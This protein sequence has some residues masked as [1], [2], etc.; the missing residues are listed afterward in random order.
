MELSVALGAWTRDTKRREILWVW[1]S[2]ATEVPQ[3]QFGVV[4][5]LMRH[6]EAERP[7]RKGNVRCISAACANMGGFATVVMDCS[8]HG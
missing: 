6:G 7:H 5:A 4:P 1:R 3:Q 8:G 2:H